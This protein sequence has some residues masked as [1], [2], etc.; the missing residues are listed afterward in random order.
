M[1]A[2]PGSGSGEKPILVHNADPCKEALKRFPD[3][4]HLRGVDPDEVLD[5]IPDHWVV[6]DLTKP[7][8]KGGGIKFRNPNAPGQSI[9]YEAGWLG[10]SDPTHRGPYLKMRDRGLIR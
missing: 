3:V 6:E 4:D 2:R 1:A 10:H 7:P 5:I 9:I 8:T